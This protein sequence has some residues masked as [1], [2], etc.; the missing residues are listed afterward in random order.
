MGSDYA[1]TELT[2][3]RSVVMN[4]VSKSYRFMAIDPE[5]EGVTCIQLF[6]NTP[7]MAERMAG[8]SAFAYVIASTGVNAL[9]EMLVATLVTGAAAAALKKARLI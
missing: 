9:V 4:G 2:S 6:G 5:R 8:K 3:A 1:P 7:E